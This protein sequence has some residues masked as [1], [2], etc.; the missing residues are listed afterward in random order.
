MR[1]AMPSLLCG[2]IL[3]L[4][5]CTAESCTAIAA[6]P[7]LSITLEGAPAAAAERL[8]VSACTDD[9]CSTTEVDLALG[10]TTTEET[11]APDGTCRAVA[12][13]DGTLT[14]FAELDLPE[15]EVPTGVTVH[16]RD[17][18]TAAYTATVVPAMVHPNGEHCDGGAIQGRLVLDDAGLRSG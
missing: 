12:T 17:G 13:P 15:D 5:S 9:G 7:G 14:G 8:E 1:T 11:C 3:A 6:L 2:L 18:R 4:P 16:Q 10:S